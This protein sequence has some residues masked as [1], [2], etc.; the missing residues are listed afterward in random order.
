MRPKWDQAL[1][2][3]LGHTTFLWN[4]KKLTNKI[5]FPGDNLQAC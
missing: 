4:E 3:S 2:K 1:E 5:Y